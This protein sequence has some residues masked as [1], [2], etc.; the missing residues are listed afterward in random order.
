[1][2]RTWNAHHEELLLSAADQRIVQQAALKLVKEDKI[3]QVVSYI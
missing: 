1:M 2:S 3:G